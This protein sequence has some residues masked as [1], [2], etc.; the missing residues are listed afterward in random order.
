MIVNDLPLAVKSQRLINVIVDMIAFLTIW[1]LLIIV[2]T[3]LG[4]DQTY[5]DEN[6]EQVP[7]IP[8]VILVPTFWA[9][10]F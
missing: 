6:G 5:I 1:I 3:L 4:F 8:F 9:I 2:I 10:T 7:L